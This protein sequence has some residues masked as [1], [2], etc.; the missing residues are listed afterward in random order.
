MKKAFIQLHI[1]VFLA[2]FT[3][4]LGKLITLNEGLLVWYRLLISAAS[5]WIIALLRRR[6]SRI[7]SGAMVKIFG[8]GAVAA[9]HWVS[10]Y[11]SIK[12]A[13]VSIAL[14]C[15]SAIGFFTAILE[16]IIFKQ[17]F[18]R[19]ELLLGILVMIGISFIFQFDPRYRQGI[20]VGIIAAIL[21][22]IFP[23]LSRK[24]LQQFDAETVT[25]YELSGGLIFLSLLL[26]VYL[27]LFPT[28]YLIP[29]GHDLFWLLILSWICTVV[30]FS[31]SMNALRKISAFTVNL[32]FN[33]EPIYGIM[34]A[35]FIFREDKFLGP[36]FYA[37][38]SL[39]FLAIVLQMAALYRENGKNFSSK[40]V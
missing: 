21:G 18:H 22:S 30:A 9:L 25:L 2:G 7:S 32:T 35:F 3:G 5:L 39:I 38:L 13:N 14:V 10:F 31:L 34:L 36:G 24:L 29:D 17:K 4:I 12:L 23:I 26:P 8:I 27:K 28:Q 19:R 16:P 6:I 15:F 11:G 33:L 1:A 37:G 40:K 20:L